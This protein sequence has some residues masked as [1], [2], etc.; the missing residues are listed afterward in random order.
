VSP[1]TVCLALVVGLSLLSAACGAPPE[2]LPTSPPLPRVSGNLPAGGL[3]PS[4]APTTG[5][6]AP[7]VTPPALPGY[8]TPPPQP[9]TTLTTRPTTP[10]ATSS[11]PS[12]TPSRAPRCTSEPTGAQIIAKAK[13]SPAVPDGN[14]AVVD[15]PYC[16][17]AWSFTVLG[18]TG[19]ESLSVV[20]TGTGTALTLVTA[21][22]DVC[23]PRVKA[24]APPGIR[25]LAC[26]Y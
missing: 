23:N 6:S 17:G 8:G 25:V 26:G 22:T 19:A 7:A 24:E 4:A 15:G 12:P 9:T 13:E 1:R 3:A 10:P 11:S 2:S 5:W 14:L 21:G 18:M 16:S 20:A